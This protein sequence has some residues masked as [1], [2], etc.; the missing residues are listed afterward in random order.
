M[1]RISKRE[2]IAKLSLYEIGY[3][4]L[5]D[6][7]H[8]LNQ[9]NKIRVAISVLQIFEKDDTKTKT[10][11]IVQLYIPKKADDETDYRR[12]VAASGAAGI[13]PQPPGV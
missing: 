13:I 12:L 9:A 10:N 1:A 4:Y 11:Q 5:R 8:K 3:E 7:F 2:T 6:N